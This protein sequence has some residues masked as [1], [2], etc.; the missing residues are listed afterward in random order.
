[1]YRVRCRYE[2]GL[3]RFGGQRAGSAERLAR[4]GA[5]RVVD[6]DDMSA[7]YDDALIAVCGAGDYIVTWKAA[8]IV[9]VPSPRPQRVGTL[10]DP[11]KLLKAWQQAKRRA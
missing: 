8:R 6:A 9:S 5:W 7:S 11:F 10:A 1:M 3:R 4:F 2:P